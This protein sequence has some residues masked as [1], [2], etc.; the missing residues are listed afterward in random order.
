MLSVFSVRLCPQYAYVCHIFNCLQRNSHSG[1]PI[2]CIQAPHFEIPGSGDFPIEEH[3]TSKDINQRRL[4]SELKEKNLP[5]H[6]L[7]PYLVNLFKCGVELT[8]AFSTR[9]ASEFQSHLNDIHDKDL[10]SVILCVYCRNLNTVSGI[11]KHIEVEHGVCRF[12][13]PYCPYRAVKHAF[14]SL[15]LVC[16][17]LANCNSL[18]T[19]YIDCIYTSIP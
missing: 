18:F 5:A 13:C 1:S 16:P 11:V 6:Q 14:I 10:D 12:L 4:I 3:S 9:I 15:H 7:Q 2:R 8:C 19:V 17:F